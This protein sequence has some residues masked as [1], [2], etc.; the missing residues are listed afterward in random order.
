MAALQV[1]NYESI[2]LI[3]RFHVINNDLKKLNICTRQ[4]IFQSILV[5]AL[6]VCFIFIQK[7]NQ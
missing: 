1:D 2:T 4:D 6:V 7:N 5:V 3:K